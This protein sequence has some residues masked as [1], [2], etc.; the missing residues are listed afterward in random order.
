MT[1]RGQSSSKNPASRQMFSAHHEKL[2]IAALA[3]DPTRTFETIDA[4]YRMFVCLFVCFLEGYDVG[5]AFALGIEND[6][7]LFRFLK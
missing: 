1:V 6:P 3:R 4:W 2:W 5:P 7:D